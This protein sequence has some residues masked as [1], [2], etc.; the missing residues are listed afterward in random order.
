MPV[1]NGEKYL[2]RSI[3]HFLGQDYENK[4]LVIVDGKS[5]DGSHDIIKKYSTKHKEVVWVKEEDK[6]LS[7]AVN[8][9]IGR[10]TGDMVG[11]LGADDLLYKGILSEIGY[12]AE[13]IPTVDALY[14]DSITYYPTTKE[15]YLRKCPYVR[16]TKENLLK[17]GTIVGLQNIFFRR[18]VFDRHLYDTT[19][20][21]SFDYEFYMR[22]TDE[23]E[24]SYLYVEKVATIDI[25]D[26]NISDAL[27]EKQRKEVIKV[28]KRY[29]QSGQA[30][31]Y[32]QRTETFFLPFLF[33]KLMPWLFR[34]RKF[35]EEG[36]YWSAKEESSD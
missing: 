28:A 17:H 12:L 23:D 1:M 7:D 18:S 34:E 31:F 16:F 36:R 4:E 10:S 32:E 2:E 29:R 13:T 14:F 30:V 35:R 19:N 27:G 21:W 8:I 26:G 22:L 20:R 25:F 6:G 11:Y 5:T 9:G 3:Q 33:Y 15:L 24:L